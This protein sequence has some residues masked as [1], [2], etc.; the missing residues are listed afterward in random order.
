[1]H[2]QILSDTRNSASCAWTGH[3]YVHLACCVLPDLRPRVCK[4]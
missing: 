4:Q 2:L 3:K 1:L